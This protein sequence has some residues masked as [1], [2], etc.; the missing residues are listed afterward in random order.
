M[1]IEQVQVPII[2]V[3]SAIAFTTTIAIGCGLIIAQLKRAV[4]ELDRLAKAVEDINARVIR[5]ETKIE[6]R[7]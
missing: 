1:T 6:E 7:Q 4:A 2:L 5:L 3:L